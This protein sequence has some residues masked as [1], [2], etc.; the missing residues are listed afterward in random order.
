MAV[1]KPVGTNASF[2]PS[3]A[4]PLLLLVYR[5]RDFN[6]ASGGRWCTELCGVV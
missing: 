3:Q 2:S 1:N 5:P 6:A 4:Q